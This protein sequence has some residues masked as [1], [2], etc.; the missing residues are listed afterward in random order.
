MMLRP[1]VLM[2]G[3]VLRDAKLRER[4]GEVARRHLKFAEE[5]FK[6][7]DSRGC[8]RKTKEGGVWVVPAFGIDLKTGGW[9]AGYGTRLETGFS[10]PANKQNH[11]ATWLLAMH[12][13]TGDAQYLAPARMWFQEM[14]SR[15]RVV[16][17]GKRWVWNYWDP[18]GPW[19]FKPDHSPR[20]WVGVHPNGGYYSIDVDAVVDAFEHGVVFTKADIDRLIATNRDFMWNQKLTGASFGRIDGEA[21]DARWAKSPGLLWTRLLPYDEVLRSVFVANHDPAGWGGIGITPWYLS[22]ARGAR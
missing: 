5:I 22:L 1:I 18:A 10:N 16:G 6:K 14:R 19:D 21:P 17:E 2:A 15:M 8:W 13:A 11:I 20:H 4:R 12:E 3:E 9:S 7:W